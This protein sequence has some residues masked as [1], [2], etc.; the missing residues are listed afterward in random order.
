MKAFLATLGKELRQLARDRAGLA[1]LFLMPMVLVV[2]VS[3][4]QENVMRSIGAV[5]AR[6]WLVDRD[7]GEVG[8]RLARTLR[9][10]GGVL[11]DV[12]EDPASVTDEAVR[13][14]AGKGRYQF[15]IVI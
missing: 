8:K 9:E 7:G 1:V 4:V 10:G 11:L 5:S 14:A 15:C 3:L 2:V 6:A 13:E 12:A